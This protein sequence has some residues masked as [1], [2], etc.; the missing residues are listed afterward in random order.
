MGRI[1]KM[2]KR[3]RKERN[4][5]EKKVE[6]RYEWKKEM[7]QSRGDGD[8]RGKGEG[9]RGGVGE[10][11]WVVGWTWVKEVMEVGP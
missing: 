2:A 4:G 3:R 6:G 5:G 7:E 9:G 10:G 8:N 1:Q 11:E